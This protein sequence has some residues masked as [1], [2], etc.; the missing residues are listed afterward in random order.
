MIDTA[1]EAYSRGLTPLPLRPRSKAP[2]VKGWPDLRYSSADEIRW[3]WRGVQARYPGEDLNVGVTLGRNHGGLIN[4]DV[5]DDRA[6]TL[7][8]ELLPHTPAMSGRESAPGHFWYR[9]PGYDPGLDKIQLPDGRVIIEIRGTGC[10][11]VLPPSI[12]P[13]GEPY[14]WIREPFGGSDGLTPIDDAG[15]RRIHANALLVALLVT[16]AD[17]WPERGSRHAAYLPLVGGLLRDAD[18]DGRPRCHPLWD[19]TIGGIIKGLVVLTNDRDGARTRSAEVVDTTRKKINN[20]E[21]VHGWPTLAEM[22]G[23][24]HVKSARQI[25]K[26]IETLLD[27]PRRAPLSKSTTKQPATPDGEPVESLTQISD[28]EMRLISQMKPDDQRDPLAERLSEWE[29]VD[30]GPYLRGGITPPVPGIITRS[31]GVGLIYPGRVNSLYG[32]GGSGKTLLALDVARQ[33]MEADGTVLF[34]DFEDEPNGTLDR[35]L[36][37][38][39]R[40]ELLQTSF[41][42]VRPEYEPLADMQIDRWGNRAVT[43]TGRKSAEALAGVIAETEPSLIIIDGTTSLYRAHGQDPNAANGTDVIGSWLRRLTENGA[44]T[45]LMIDHTSKNAPP[46]ATP[47]GSQHKIAMIQGTALHVYATTKPRRGSTGIGR[48]YVGKDRPGG[49]LEHST[50]DDPYCAAEITYR[51]DSQGRLVIDLDPPNPSVVA[52]QI[53]NQT[54]AQQAPAPAPAA[55]LTPAAGRKRGRPPAQPTGPDAGPRTLGN[56]DLAVLEVMRN[57]PGTPLKISE[58]ELACALDLARTNLARILQR[59]VTE[60]HL[61]AIGEKSGRRYLLDAT[62]RD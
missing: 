60:G 18:D 25:I 2:A 37:L 8:V 12:H 36:L 20:G 47:M 39:T 51:S 40:P 56:A 32:E 55:T 23:E 21:P 22:I 33:H 26:K 16:L 4:I 41:A 35:L 44:R 3:L 61:A 29:R 59:L 38:G 57:H 13:N 46:G 50:V 9:C 62:S 49:V 27:M 43:D 42:Y 7:A 30:I 5:D 52:V 10:Q 28:E 14:K 24:D 53:G 58:I 34:I 45:V 6:R 17:A 19:A 1:L 54:A 48:L 15:G 31:D 11:T